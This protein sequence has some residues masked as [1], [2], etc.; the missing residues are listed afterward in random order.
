MS[1][2]F[3]HARGISLGKVSRRAS[4]ADVVCK[5]QAL[6]WAASESVNAPQNLRAD[7]DAEPF[8]DFVRIRCVRRSVT[9]GFRK[10]HGTFSN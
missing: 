4:Q 9:R 6:H 1:I 8:P 7:S 2:A 3:I 10:S 5:R